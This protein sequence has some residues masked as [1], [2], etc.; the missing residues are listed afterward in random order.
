MDV[1]R[2]GLHPLWERPIL[3]N[4]D[5]V[6]FRCVILMTIITVVL[7]HVCNYTYVDVGMRMVSAEGL[8]SGTFVRVR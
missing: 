6:N 2:L 5:G 3:Y 1:S 4:S 8:L 7:M